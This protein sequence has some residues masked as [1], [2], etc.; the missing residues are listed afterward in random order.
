M[1]GNIFS[2]LIGIIILGISFINPAS[3]QLETNLLELN[4]AKK[5]IKVGITIKNNSPHP[6]TIAKPILGYN[7]Y[8]DFVSEE[9]KDT[10][11]YLKSVE[12]DK[13]N[14]FYITLKPESKYTKIL[15]LNLKKTGIQAGE[16]KRGN[17]YLIVH[18]VSNK[19]DYNLISD[20][21]NRNYLGKLKSN[22][23]YF[24]L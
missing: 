11:S 20:N 17:Y 23:L 19:G 7:L 4:H 3:L 14:S 21:T 22:P 18:F 9:S 15:E 10:L 24:S 2:N 13:R 6:I 1:S 5:I 12:P 8:Y 16:I